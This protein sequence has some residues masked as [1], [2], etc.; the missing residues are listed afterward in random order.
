MRAALGLYGS[1]ALSL[2]Q[3][4]PIMYLALSNTPGAKYL[5]M[6]FLGIINALLASGSNITR[7]AQSAVSTV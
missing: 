2:L 6:L 7:S 5:A 4:F 1:E 3:G